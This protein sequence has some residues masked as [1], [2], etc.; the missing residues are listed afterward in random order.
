[1]SLFQHFLC[2]SY[3]FGLILNPLNLRNSVALLCYKS[4]GTPLSSNHLRQD[5]LYKIN[6]NAL[7]FLNNYYCTL[8]DKTFALLQ[9]CLCVL[10]TL[11]MQSV[12]E[13]LNITVNFSCKYFSFFVSLLPV[14]PDTFSLSLRNLVPL[15]S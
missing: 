12:M 5:Y 10:F 14:R 3:L 6:I 2:H 13:E 1:M 8:F 11:L 9:Q 15:L 4:T 7:M